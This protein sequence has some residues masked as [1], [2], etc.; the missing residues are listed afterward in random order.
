[1]NPVIIYNSTL[2]SSKEGLKSS[3]NSKRMFAEFVDEER[4]T[5]AEVS[6]KM[7]I[8]TILSK[9][10]DDRTPEDLEILTQFMTRY[11]FFSK[12]KEDHDIET[13]HQVMRYLKVAKIELN[14]YL[15]QQGEEGDR[16]YVILKGLVAV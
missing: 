16:F 6:L 11:K 4:D 12:L 8:G 10:P 15:I 9:G 14:Q 2:Q 3:L 13:V 5:P 7:K 1:M